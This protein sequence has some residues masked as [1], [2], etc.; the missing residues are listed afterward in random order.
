MLRICRLP[1]LLARLGWGPGGCGRLLVG[2]AGLALSAGLVSWAC[3]CGLGLR[4]LGLVCFFFAL[5]FGASD[6]VETL[7]DY[8]ALLKGIAL[9][10]L[11]RASF[12]MRSGTLPQNLRDEL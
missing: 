10:G 9:E 8:A 3:R 6:S 2:R 1:W 5:L 12:R 7:L 11:T 4:G